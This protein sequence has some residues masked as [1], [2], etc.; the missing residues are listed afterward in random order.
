MTIAKRLLASLSAL[1]SN[2]GTRNLV[3][4]VAHNRIGKRPESSDVATQ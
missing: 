4:R 3:S 2:G 1:S